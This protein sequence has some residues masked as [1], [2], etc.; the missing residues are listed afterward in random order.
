[1]TKKEALVILGL[2]HPANRQMIESRYARLIK[3]YHRSD[4]EK[5]AEV[6]EAYKT[7]TEDSRKVEIAPRLQKKV[8]GKSL[9]QWK[10]VVH[11]ARVPALVTLLVLALVIGIIYS[12]VTKEDP[13]FIIAAIGS[14]YNREDNLVENQDELYT[15]NEFVLEHMAV[16]RPL[17]DLLS[18]GSN[19]DPQMEMANM[20]KRILY[21]GG[22]TPANLLLLDEA[23]FDSFQIEGVLFPL[24]NFYKE[25]QAAYNS[26][27]LD[28]IKPVYGHIALTDEEVEEQKAT[29]ETSNVKESSS[30]GLDDW[31]SKET[32]IVGFDLSEKQIFNGLSMLGY[33]QILSVPVQSEDREQAF[34]FIRLLIEYQDEIQTH[35]PGLVNPSPTPTPSPTPAP[36]ESDLAETTAK[37]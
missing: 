23:N 9:Y 31:I 27:E 8:A 19:Q 3:G 24:E 15:I 5:M 2:E 36:S 16:E 10:N 32:Y 18:I 30:T 6:N 37:P 20:T 4:P 12:V 25:L 13:D 17:V 34:A 1:M 11:Y 33:Q 26:E 29:V 14:F 21:A 28:F 35:S 22:M 7:L